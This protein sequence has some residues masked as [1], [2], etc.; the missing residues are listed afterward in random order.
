MKTAKLKAMQHVTV[1]GSA[2]VECDWNSLDEY[3]M[4]V[5]SQRISE[6]PRKLANGV[7]TAEL[8]KFVSCRSPSPRYAVCNESNQIICT[9]TAS[10]VS[11]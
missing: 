9:F 11:A 8:S 4:T 6:S 7:T 2:D 1:T 5:Y 10:G 3:K